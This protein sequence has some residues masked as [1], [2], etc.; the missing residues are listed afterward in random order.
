MSRTESHTQLARKKKRDFGLSYGYASSHRQLHYN[1]F[2]PSEQQTRTLKLI[3]TVFVD[4]AFTIMIAHTRV[5]TPNYLCTS[6]GEKGGG[7]GGGRGGGR[8]GGRG[9][10]GGG[11]GRG[12][13][14]GRGRRGRCYKAA[15]TIDDIT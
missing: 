3:L 14:R 6:F 15:R 8:E 13:G 7:G 12:G 4:R 5:G 11:G 2:L 10:G 1:K 9:R